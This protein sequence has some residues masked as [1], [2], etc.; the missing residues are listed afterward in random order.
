MLSIKSF[1]VDEPCEPPKINIKGF[2]DSK[3]SIFLA[4]SLSKISPFKREGLV[5]LPVNAILARKDSAFFA[6]FCIP[7]ISS[8]AEIK[9]TAMRSAKDKANLLAKPIVESES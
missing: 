2:S 6:F 5:G 1:I 4:V 8:A 3:P 9:E 7:T